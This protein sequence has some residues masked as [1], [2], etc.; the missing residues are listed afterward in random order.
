MKISLTEMIAENYA[1]VSER[2]A[3]AACSVGRDAGV[4]KLIVV[5]KGHT[6]EVAQAAIQAGAKY[7]GENYVQDALPK[8]ETLA[9]ADVEWHMIGH[10]QSR[11]AR[12]VVENFAWMHSL[13]RLKLARRCDQFAAQ[14]N[15][16]LPVL[17]ECNV[18]GEVSKHGWPV[19]D[20]S[21]WSV[22]AEELAP[23]FDFDHLEVRGLMTMPPFEH[24]PEDAR[25]YFQKL[26]R[27]R[28]FL[29]DHFPQTD[30]RELSMGMSNDFEVAIQEG[31]TIIRVGTAIVGARSYGRIR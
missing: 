10:V 8:I 5:A 2:L 20:E 29:S 7:L 11:K 17:L 4:I 13:D 1:D 22:F 31:A 14:A 6:V 18:S 15:R 23:V 25:P 9:D 26:C 3:A 24:N 16:K 12:D 27:L 21:R 30:W 28:D 19:W